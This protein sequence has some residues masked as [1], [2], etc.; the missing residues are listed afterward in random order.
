MAHGY[1][2]LSRGPDVFTG[3]LHALGM[4]EPALLAWAT[5]VVELLGGLAVL[6]G[7]FLPL[8]SLPMIFVL[9]VATFT[10]HLPNGFSSIKLEFG[11]GFGSSFRP[12]RIR[13]R[14]ALH[15]LPRRPWGRPRRSPDLQWLVRRRPSQR[16]GRFVRCR[17]RLTPLHGARLHSAPAMAGRCPRLSSGEGIPVAAPLTLARSND[18][19]LVLSAGNA[20]SHCAS[21]GPT[22]LAR[23]AIARSI[24]IGEIRIELV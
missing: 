5:I 6:I 9:L 12:T 13:D 10:V 7:C 8:V 1:A 24:T 18:R 2:K 14:P 22:D 4:P 16:S 21:P 15:R 3:I 19:K 17:R 23:S 11:Y 20:A